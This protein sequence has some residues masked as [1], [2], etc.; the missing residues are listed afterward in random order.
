MKKLFILLLISSC[1]LN[2]KMTEPICQENLEF[3]KTFFSSINYMDSINSLNYKQLNNLHV[4][5]IKTIIERQKGDFEL[6]LNFI[7][8]YAQVSWEKR[9]HY[10]IPYSAKDYEQ[11]KLGWLRWY[12]ENKCSNIQFKLKNTSK[13]DCIENED[14]KTKFFLSIDNVENYLLNKGERNSYETSLAFISQY[15]HVS[16][17]KTLN[18]DNT[19]PFKSFQEDKSN[20]L[21]WYEENKCNNIQI[22]I[23]KN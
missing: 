21:K 5:S 15:T 11:D 4:D 14:F 8:Q 2:L 20:W 10:L 19:F 3:K 9:I 6:S 13:T 1:S 22:K 16:Y 12:E 17:E 7:S 23:G 18:Y